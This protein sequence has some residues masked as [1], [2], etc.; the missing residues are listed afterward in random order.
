VRR[1]AGG[2]MDA[3]A[4]EIPFERGDLRAGVYFYRLTA[5]AETQTGSMV[6]E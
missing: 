5:G 1:V 3:G 2:M 4:H 6:I